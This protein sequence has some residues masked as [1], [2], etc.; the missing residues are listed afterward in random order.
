M[1]DKVSFFQNSYWQHHQKN[2][3][4]AKTKNTS[5]VIVF[6]DI[7]FLCFSDDENDIFWRAV[8]IVKKD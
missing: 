8:S 2:V 5:A 3:H 1:A 4:L 7:F 6:Q